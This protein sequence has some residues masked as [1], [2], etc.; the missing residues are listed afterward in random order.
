MIVTA[1]IQEHYTDTAAATEQVF[2]LCAFLGFRYAPRMAHMLDR[3]LFT[4]GRPGDYGPLNSL[5]HGGVN[6]RLIREQWAEKQRIAASIRHGTSPASVLMRKLASYPRQNR[7]AAAFT[8]MGKVERTLSL[9]ELMHDETMQRRIQTGLNKGESS[10]GLAR[11]VL[12]GRK[13]VLYDRTY[14]LNCIVPV[15]WS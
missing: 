3:Q 9:L 11:A 5:V 7:V 10:N 8:E 12:S 15:A 13:G 6:Q 4:I 1:H 2:A 14:R